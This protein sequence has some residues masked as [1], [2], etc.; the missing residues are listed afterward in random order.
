MVCISKQ[1]RNE[2]RVEGI[3]WSRRRVVKKGRKKGV[4]MKRRDIQLKVNCAI[5]SLTKRLPNPIT[6]S[7][8]FHHL[9]H[10]TA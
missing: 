8:Y 2:R 4:R 5:N 7:N 3:G 10:S 1:Y 6:T 9:S